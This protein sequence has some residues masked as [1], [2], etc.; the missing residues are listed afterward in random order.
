M[1]TVYT[2]YSEIESEKV[3][4]GIR[5]Y[6]DSSCP[7]LLQFFSY[8]ATVAQLKVVTGAKTPLHRALAQRVG[9]A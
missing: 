5:A 8:A 7:I 2:V 6:T 3:S 4:N 9:S 1:R